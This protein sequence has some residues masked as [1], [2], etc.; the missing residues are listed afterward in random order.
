MKKQ[1]RHRKRP[2]TIARMIQIIGRQDP[3]QQNVHGKRKN[4]TVNGDLTAAGTVNRHA[5]KLRHFEL[6]KINQY[7]PMRPA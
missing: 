3:V 5:V 2:K 1:T 6:K 4:L 7:Q